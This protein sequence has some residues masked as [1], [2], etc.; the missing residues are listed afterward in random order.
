MLQAFD[1]VHE[2]RIV[3]LG[4]VTWERAGWPD[5][6]ELADQEVK[7]VEALRVLRDV[8]NGLQ[9]EALERERAKAPKRSRGPHRPTS[10][11]TKAR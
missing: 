2:T 10:R 1:L 3:G 5:A 9:T 4:F 8:H 6:G 7:T 11:P